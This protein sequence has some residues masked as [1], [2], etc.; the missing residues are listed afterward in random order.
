MPIVLT[1]MVQF[2]NSFFS[3]GTQNIRRMHSFAKSVIICEEIQSL[4][5]KC[6]DFLTRRLIFYQLYVMQ[7]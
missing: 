2:L 1:T 3:G 6:V 5:T 4:P 7:Q